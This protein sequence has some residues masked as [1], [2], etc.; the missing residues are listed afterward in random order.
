MR[1]KSIPV[2]LA[3][4]VLGGLAFADALPDQS[5]LTIYDG[6]TLVGSGTY[7]GGDLTLNV[8][9]SF[10]G[11]ATLTVTTRGG[12]TLTYDVSVDAGGNV[13]L[14]DSGTPLSEINPSIAKRGGSVDIEQVDSVVEPTLPPPGPN[15]HANGNATDQALNAGDGMNNAADQATGG[16]GADHADGHAWNG[17]Q[18]AGS[19]P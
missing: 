6:G 15:A 9:S 5:T 19:H 13:T 11:D 12:D 8:L 18:N 4:T 2:I 10:S 14:S 7:V 17:S 16:T 1:W 3:V